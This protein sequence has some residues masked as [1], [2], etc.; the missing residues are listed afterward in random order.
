[1]RSK[2]SH[3]LLCALLLVLG[4]AAAAQAQIK[5]DPANYDAMASA[6]SSDTI[7]PGTR[8]TLQN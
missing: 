8:I 3:S 1:M 6:D 4:L 2:L 5:W 7:A